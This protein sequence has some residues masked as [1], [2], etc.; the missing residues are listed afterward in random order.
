MSTHTITG[1]ALL[2]DPRLNKATAFSDAEHRNLGLARMSH[3]LA[4]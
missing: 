2:R 4:G 3:T 1:D